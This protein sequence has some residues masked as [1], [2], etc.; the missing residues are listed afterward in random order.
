MKRR[1]ARQEFK[2][3]RRKLKRWIRKATVQNVCPVCGADVR[4]ECGCT[5]AVELLPEYG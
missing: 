4:A 5:E 3:V 1:T 2:T